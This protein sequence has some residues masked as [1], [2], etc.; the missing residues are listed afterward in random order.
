[1]VEMNLVRQLI[2]GNDS[3]LSGAH[4]TVWTLVFIGVSGSRLSG[5]KSIC[6]SNNYEVECVLKAYAPPLASHLRAP[7]GEV[8][9]FNVNVI[10]KVIRMLH[11]CSSHTQQ[12]VSYPLCPS[13]NYEVEYVLRAYA[14]PLVPHLRA[15]QGEVFI[16][17]VNTIIKEVDKNATR[18]F[19]SYSTRCLIPP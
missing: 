11:G 8:F 9:I 13:N 19:K 1:M 10:I 12:G 7:Q 14:P 17:N 4:L 15:S 18:V 5:L 3:L 2:V 16:F 6:P